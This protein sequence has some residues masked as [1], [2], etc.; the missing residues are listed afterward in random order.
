MFVAI[1]AISS[2]FQVARFVARRWRPL[3]KRR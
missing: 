1:Y 2:M 3:L